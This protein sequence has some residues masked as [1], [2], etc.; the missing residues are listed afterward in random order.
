LGIKR[1]NGILYHGKDPHAQFWH[2]WFRSPEFQVQ[3]GD[4]G[5]LFSLAG[6]GSDVHARL[7]DSTNKRLGWIYMTRQ[8]HFN[9]LHHG[10]HQEHPSP[11]ATYRI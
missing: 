7:K 9:I 11:P 8:L 4:M 1:D 5:D 3:E 6:V 10:Q 2:V